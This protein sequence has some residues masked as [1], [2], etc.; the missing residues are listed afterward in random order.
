M[1][2]HETTTVSWVDKALNSAKSGIA[3]IGGLAVTVAGLPDV[4]PFV[5]AQYRPEVAL[6]LSVITAIAVWWTKNK[7][8]PVPPPATPAEPPA[9]G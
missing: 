8:L 3:L 4:T 7:P 9:Q 5:P 1:G 6:V 2:N